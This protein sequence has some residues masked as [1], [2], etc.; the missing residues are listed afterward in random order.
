MATSKTALEDY[1]AQ[2]NGWARG[3]AQA[4]EDIVFDFL[5][6]GSLPIHVQMFVE[7][8]LDK[9]VEYLMMQLAFIAGAFKNLEVLLG[10]FV[11]E[12][13]L[14]AQAVGN[15]DADRFLEWL[16]GAF[17]L[18]RKQ[19]DYVACQRA[20]FAVEAQARQDRRGHVRFQELGSV[21]G[22]LA[23]S[24]G[25]NARLRIHLNPIRAWS[26]FETTELL[27]G[28]ASL[29]ANVLFFPV[30]ESTNTAVLESAGQALLEELIA[31]GPWTLGEW[32]AVSAQAGREELIGF[33][34][35]LADM[36]LVAFS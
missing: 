21:A 13:P 2:L 11:L 23:K 22:K 20:R 1:R 17:K 29:P 14:A 36:G 34:R 18:T 33:C 6:P 5:A 9:R 31:G 30:R 15:N 24:L 26:S 10:A 25:H 7:G 27:D 35:S 4:R 8:N 3:M 12:E 16:P 28:D 32:A 19:R